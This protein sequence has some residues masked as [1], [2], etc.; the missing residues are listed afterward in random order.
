MVSLLAIP[1]TD[2]TCAL[3]SEFT[4]CLSCPT[5][6]S[7]SNQWICAC[8]GVVTPKGGQV[9]RGNE[10]LGCP[11]CRHTSRNSSGSALGSPVPRGGEYG[12][13]ARHQCVILVRFL[14]IGGRIQTP[15]LLFR[16]L[17]IT[18]GDHDD[19]NMAQQSV[20]FSRLKTRSPS[21]PGISR[22]KRM[23]WG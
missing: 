7:I 19:R 8:P 13:E 17:S 15:C 5:S 2:Q 10:A 16:F 4:I 6:K 1:S 20:A 14:N 3:P 22:S 23:A 21:P 18:D 11:L 9:A 12:P